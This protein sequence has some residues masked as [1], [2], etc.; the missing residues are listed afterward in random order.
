MEVVGGRK[1][2][3]E[4]E[5]GREREREGAQFTRTVKI[6]RKLVKPRGIQP[7]HLQITRSC[8][9]PKLT[10]KKRGRPTNKSIIIRLFPMLTNT[11]PHRERYQQTQS[12][13][14]I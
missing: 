14:T 11:H 3:A 4:R 9:R 5:G 10:N 1:G 2:G 12:T 7:S 6:T 13:A 8:P